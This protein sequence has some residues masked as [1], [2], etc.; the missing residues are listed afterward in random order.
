[1]YFKL[2]SKV[3][4]YMYIYDL[5]LMTNTVMD[6][7]QTGYNCNAAADRGGIGI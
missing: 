4:Y 7:Q 6:R 1:M 5:V 2:V 3:Y